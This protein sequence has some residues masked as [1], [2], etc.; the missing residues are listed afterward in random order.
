MMRSTTAAADRL[1]GVRWPLWGGY[2]HLL[3]TEPEV[4]KSAR[5]IVDAVVEDVDRAASLF[6]DDSELSRLN[7]SRNGS[8]RVSA[9]LYELLQSA[10]R[11]AETTNGAVDLTVGVAVQRHAARAPASDPTASSVRTVSTV[12]RHSWRA[13][14]LD[15]QQRSVDVPDGIE[16][17]L[18]AS[19]KAVTADLAAR[20]VANQ[21]G[22]GVLVNLGGDLAIAGAAPTGGWPIR[23]ADDH[24]NDNGPGLTVALSTGGLATSSTTVRGWWSGDRWL[25][26]IVD[27]VTG[28]PARV[29]WRTVS[30]AAGSCLEANAAAMAAIVMGHNAPVWLTARR[31]P[32]RLVAADG[33]VTTLGAWPQETAS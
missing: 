2:A 18:G 14:R 19:A 16:L 6:R 20:A 9:C 1:A 5:V 15:P 26:H 22:C 3:V 17:D 23:I 8:M 33:S 28:W 7:R 32:S 24:R 13:L 10:L 21:T 30:V 27:P 12:R 29:V 4:L 31:H 11:A 25:H